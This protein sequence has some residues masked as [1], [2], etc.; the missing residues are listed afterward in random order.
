MGRFVLKILLV[1][2]AIG[3]TAGVMPGIEIHGGLG[4]LLWV[5]LLF[6]LVNLLLKPLAQLISLPL[7]LVTLGLF[8]LVVNACMLLFTAWLTDGLEIDGF[9][10]AV[11]GSILISLVLMVAEAVL[12]PD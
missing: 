7:I 12:D 1:A 4:T 11:W 10:P 2:G 8:A 3:T 5:A 6:T 9:W